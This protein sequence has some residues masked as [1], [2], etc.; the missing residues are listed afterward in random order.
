[1]KHFLS[2]YNILYFCTCI[3]GDT[4]EAQKNF[5]FDHKFLHRK[6]SKFRASA[7]IILKSMWHFNTCKFSQ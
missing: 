2:K 7:Q 5:T 3:A 4:T 6:W 1:M